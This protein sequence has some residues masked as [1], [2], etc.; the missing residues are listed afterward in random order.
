M[1]DQTRV[2]E[3][4]RRFAGTLVHEYD[5]DE[6]MSAFGADVAEIL[7]AAGAGAMVA[8]ES[9][10]LRF[11]ATSEERLDEL[12]R[13]QIELEEGPCLLAYLTGQP[14]VAADLRTDERFPRFGPQAVAAGMRAVH[15][16]PMA[17]DDTTVGALNLYTEQVSD[18]AAEA[19]ALGQSFA[20]VA[21]IYLLHARDR[22]ENE[23]LTSGLQKALDSRVVVEQAKGYLASELGVTVNEAFELIRNFARPRG[24][25]ASMV[26]RSVLAGDLDLGE[27]TAQA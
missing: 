11:V 13:L 19:R 14:V 15:S 25:K 7:G 21:T 4:L 20:D 6:V 24:I 3:V 23:R 16:F 9:G 12:E 1:I 22:A 26:A 18:L 2:A 17:L 27:L 5:L 10:D 8:D